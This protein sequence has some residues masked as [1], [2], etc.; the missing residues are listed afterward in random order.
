MARK[1]YRVN[2]GPVLIER[3]KKLTTELFHECLDSAR[4]EI[5]FPDEANISDLAFEDYMQAI[6][7]KSSE[8]YQQRIKALPTKDL[9]DILWVHESGG[10]KRSPETLEGI[11]SELTKRQL[12]E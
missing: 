5:P 12:F 10:V 6:K 3:V 1:K 7:R 4:L 2:C 9:E 11:T 8:I